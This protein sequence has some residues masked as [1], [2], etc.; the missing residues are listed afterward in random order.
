LCCCISWWQAEWSGLSRAHNSCLLSIPGENRCSD[1][2]IENACYI[3]RDIC[4]T[5]D[6]LTAIIRLKNDIPQELDYNEAEKHLGNLFKLWDEACL[7]FTP[8]GH[9]LLTHAV[10]QMILLG[11]IRDT[12]EDDIE[13]MHEISARLE[14]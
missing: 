9:S 5:L 6:A 13:H 14:A 2:K 11:G 1:K 10:D 7:N 8:K 12:L 3:H 4:S